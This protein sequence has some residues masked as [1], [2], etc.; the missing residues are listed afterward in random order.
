MSL[1]FNKTNNYLTNSTNRCKTS[2]VKIKI[3]RTSLEMLNRRVNSCKLNYFH[4]VK[5]RKRSATLL[6]AKLNN[7]NNLKTDTII[8]KVN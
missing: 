8:R 1:K 5:K 2:S 3:Y 7:V 6:V 4:K